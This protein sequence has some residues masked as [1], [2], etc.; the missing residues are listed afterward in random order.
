MFHVPYFVSVLPKQH[1]NNQSW[2]LKDKPSKVTTEWTD[3]LPPVDDILREG[4][5][6]NARPGEGVKLYNHI[7]WGGK[8]G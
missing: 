7:E 3:L 4:E 8:V 1:Y 6:P 2:F 5:A